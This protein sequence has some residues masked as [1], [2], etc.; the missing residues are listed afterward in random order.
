MNPWLSAAAIAT[1]IF[2]AYH[3]VD[4]EMCKA[5]TTSH[6]EQVLPYDAKEWPPF[7]ERID[8]NSA[9]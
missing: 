8:R 9:A 1:G 5:Q 2:L 7:P 4:D 3:A 6:K